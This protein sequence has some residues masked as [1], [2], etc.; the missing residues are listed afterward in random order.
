MNEFDNRAYYN[1]NITKAVAGKNLLLTI[2]DR[3]GENLLV[4]GGQQGLTI[5]R[6]ADSIEINSKDTDGGW[7]SKLAGMKE[8]SIDTDGLYINGDAAHKR[9]SEAFE[10]GDYVCVKVI[11][12]KEQ[13][14]MFGG[15]AAITDYPI[16]APYDDAVTYS[17]TLEGAGRLVDLTENPIENEAMPKSI[18]SDES[19]QTEVA[20]GDEE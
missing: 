16:E 13:R 15:L 12:K 1:E 7:K 19:T 9:L 14:G 20:E 5:N 18:V 17:L 2:W 3:T 4:I 6:S 11:N 8:W 10:E